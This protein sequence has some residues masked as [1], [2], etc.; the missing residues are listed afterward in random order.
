MP[1][2]FRKMVSASLLAGLLCLGF[3]AV[4]SQAEACCIYNH[5]RYNLSAGTSYFGGLVISPSDHEC[6][7]GTGGTY[8]L[9]LLRIG[10]SELAASSNVEIDVEKH[11]WISVYKESGGSWKVVSKR[12]DGTVKDVQYLKA[13]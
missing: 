1:M 6:T 10:Y 12:K 7:D 3:L 11:G 2:N 9:C 4:S 8:H 5:T 13:L